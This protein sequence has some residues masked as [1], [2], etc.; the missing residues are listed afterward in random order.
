[1]ESGGNELDRRKR[2]YSESEVIQD[3]WPFAFV[4]IDGLYEDLWTEVS[5]SFY[6]TVPPMFLAL[7]PELPFSP[8]FFS[9]KGIKQ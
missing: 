6:F 2:Q 9:N 8:E 3:E 7:P 5:Q 4:Y 1:M